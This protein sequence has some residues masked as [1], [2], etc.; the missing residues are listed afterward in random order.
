[1]IRLK[2]PY[3]Y[4]LYIF[5]NSHEYYFAYRPSRKDI[6]ELLIRH[7]I[8]GPED[9]EDIGYEITRIKVYQ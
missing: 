9:M 5:S 8:V 2:N 7:E 3:I 6:R 4:K 1:M